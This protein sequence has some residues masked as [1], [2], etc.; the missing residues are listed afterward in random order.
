VGADLAG[1]DLGLTS[2]KGRPRPVLKTMTSLRQSL[3]DL[4]VVK[5]S[6]WMLVLFFGPRWTRSGGTLFHLA[7]ANPR[8]PLQASVLRLRGGF[9]EL[10]AE[11]LDRWDGTRDGC[12]CL[13]NCRCAHCDEFSGMK[14]LLET[15]YLGPQPTIC[16][17]ETDRTVAIP[18]WPPADNLPRVSEIQHDAFFARSQPKMRSCPPGGRCLCRAIGPMFPGRCTRP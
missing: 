6:V 16:G 12:K 4:L 17:T 2:S 11:Y 7:R 13:I 5:S 1:G 18:S 14:K 9:E 3:R 10:S 8:A 15:N